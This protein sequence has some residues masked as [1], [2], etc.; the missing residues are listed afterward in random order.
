M[1]T[2][3]NLWMWATSPRLVP[4]LV[5][6]RL[7]R[8]R[9]VVLA[10]LQRWKRVRHLDESDERAFVRL[11]TFQPEF[12]SQFYW[13]VGHLG[14]VLNVFAPGLKSLHLLMPSA[15]VGPGLYIQHGDGSYIG[16]RSIGRNAWINQ[17]VTLGYTNDTD[18]P[19]LGDDVS[20]Y[21]GAKVLGAV[22]VG[23]RSIVTANAL[24]LGDVPADSTAMT[25]S[26]LIIRRTSEGAEGS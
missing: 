6:L 10:D 16:C 14:R 22:H 21:A 20:I 17:E 11:M 12:R 7:H 1:S 23:D 5:T 25:R 15:N 9:E 24:V 13:R 8:S 2:L 4:A 19:T 18:C 26:P 3:K